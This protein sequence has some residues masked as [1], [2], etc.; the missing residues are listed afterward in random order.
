MSKTSTL[1]R[2]SQLFGS[3]IHDRTSDHVSKEEATFTN[4]IVLTAPHQEAA[5][6]SAP[7]SKKA[8]IEGRK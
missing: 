8:R 7:N 5:K 1:A 4:P 2:R 3:E 6:T